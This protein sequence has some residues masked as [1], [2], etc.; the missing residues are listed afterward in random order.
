MLGLT[1]NVFIADELAIK[2]CTACEL[3]AKI[4]MQQHLL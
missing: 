4:D 1:A 2:A 3:L